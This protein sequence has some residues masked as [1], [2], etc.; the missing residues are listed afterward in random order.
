MVIAVR[1]VES[2][3]AVFVQIEDGEIFATINQKDGMVIFHDDPEKYNSPAM[4]RRLEEEVSL[5]S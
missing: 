1:T 5:I 3:L 4:L 2:Q